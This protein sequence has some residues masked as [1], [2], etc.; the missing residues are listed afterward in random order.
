MCLSF[1]WLQISVLGDMLPS[2]ISVPSAL[3][4][5][6]IF[7]SIV[8]IFKEHLQGENSNL[9]SRHASGMCIHAQAAY[10]YAF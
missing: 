4:K 3:N 7:M 10:R 2:D 5:E 9:A 1:F 6:N 8:S